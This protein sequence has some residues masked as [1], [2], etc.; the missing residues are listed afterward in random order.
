MFCMKLN[1]RKFS[2][3]SIYLGSRSRIYGFAVVTLIFR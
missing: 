2:S 1:Y 3:A